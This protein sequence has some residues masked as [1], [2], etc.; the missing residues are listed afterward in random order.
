MSSQLYT[1]EEVARRLTLHA[2]TVRRYIRDQRLKAKRIGKEYRITPADL[3]AFAGSGAVADAPVTR[4]RHVL[5]ST[6]VDVHAISSGESHRIT[7]M[8]MAG[9]NARKGEPDAPRV[10]TI[11]YQE[12]ARLRITITAGL[13]LTYELLR[14]I[15]VLLESGRG[16]DLQV[17]EGKTGGSAAL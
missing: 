15:N 17:R 8:I 12:H 2:K 10:D 11:Y 4:T 14:L 13:M 1:V 16:R 3:E 5:A 6:I 7:T 9:L